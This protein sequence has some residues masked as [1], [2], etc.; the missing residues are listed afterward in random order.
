MFQNPT[1][2]MSIGKWPN[3]LK[4]TKTWHLKVGGKAP[5]ITA[6]TDADWGNHRDN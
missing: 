4:G 6:F 1:Q 3:G 5:E 2:A